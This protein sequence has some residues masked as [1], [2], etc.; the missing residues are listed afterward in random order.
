M[1]DSPEFRER[2][3]RIQ[4]QFDDLPKDVPTTPAP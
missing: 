1:V 2:I 4:R 3:S